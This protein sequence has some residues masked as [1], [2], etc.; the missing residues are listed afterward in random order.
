HLSSV[1]GVMECVPAYASLAIYFDNSIYDHPSMEKLTLDQLQ[2]IKVE[3]G[4][5]NT[6]EIPVCYNP[7]LGLDQKRFAD[8]RNVD[9]KELVALHANTSYTVLMRGFQPGFL[10]MGEINERLRLPRLAKPRAQ[11]SAGSVG[12][13]D[14]QTGIYP[15]ESPGGWNII[16]CTP[17][18]MLDFSSPEIIP[19]QQGDLVRFTAISLEVYYQ[20]K[21]AND[22]PGN[23]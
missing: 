18:R 21:L 20:M 12:I 14:G 17:S 23:V 2:D 15:L 13:A 6:W 8:E 22:G 3:E 19:I 16:G 5:V 10:Y 9:L 11:V 1:E 7:S 4:S